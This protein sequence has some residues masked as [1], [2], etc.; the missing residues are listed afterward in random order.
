MM[1]ACMFMNEGRLTNTGA[2][3]CNIICILFVAANR[4]IAACALCSGTTFCISTD[5]LSPFWYRYVYAYITA[6]EV[7]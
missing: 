6:L 5:L 4:I 1:H 2:N 3:L 7:H